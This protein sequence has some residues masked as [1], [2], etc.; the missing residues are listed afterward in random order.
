MLFTIYNDDKDGT[1]DLVRNQ[2]PKA[3]YVCNYVHTCKYKYNLHVLYLTNPDSECGLFA[4]ANLKVFSTLNKFD[5][6]YT[7]VLRFYFL[8]SID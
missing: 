7:N 8:W 1:F 5:L 3:G 6:L 4:L 2:V